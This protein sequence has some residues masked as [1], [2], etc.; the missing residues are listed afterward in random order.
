MKNRNASRIF[1]ML[2]AMLFFMTSTASASVLGTQNGGW[3]SDMGGGAVY[4]NSSYASESGNQTENYVEYTPNSEA[5]PV[6]V[7]G[8]SVYGSRTISS[9]AEYMQKNSLRPLIG[10][11]G[12]YFSPKTGIPMGYTV[13]DGQ[14]FSKESGIQDAVGFRADGTGFI[15]KIGIDASLSHNDTK[16]NIQYINK[17]PQKGF[18]WVYM[19]DSNFSDT[20][21]TDFK[22]IYVTCSRELGDMSLNS[23]MVLRVDD[24]KISDSAIKI[25]DG[26]YVFVMDVDGQ[27]EY[28]D[29]LSHLAVG[30]TV[31][32]RNSVYGAERND[33]TSASHIMSSIGGRLLNNGVVGSGFSAGTAPRT[34]V[35]VK[36]N[37]NII[38][39]TI[40]GRQSGYSKG[41]TIAS[42]AKRMQELGC[43]DAINLDGGG[44]T[45]I[46]GIFPGSES[47]LVTNRPSDGAQ[48]R[49]ANYI[50]LQD[51]REKTDIVWYVDWREIDNNKFLAGT[52]HQLEAL[53]VYD[54]GNYKMNG[55][56]GVTY[57]IQN[58]ETAQSEVS[59]TGLVT[60]RGTGAVKVS[61]TGERYNKD[62]S[63]E[64]YESPDEICVT[65]ETTGEEV[66]E[67]TVYEGTMTNFS[68]EAGAYVG[69][70]RLLSYPS[71]FKWEIIGTLAE[72]DEDGT[73]SVKDDGTET[74]LLRVSAGG[75]VKEIP[76]NTVKKSAF[77]DVRSH[78][79]KD[80]IEKMAQSGII[81]GFNENGVS[82]F[83]PDEKITRVQFAA[84]T[85]K[86]LGI[87]IEDYSNTKLE[88]SDADSIQPWALDYVKAVTALGYIKGRSDDGGKTVY[89]DPENKI[90][91]AEAFTIVS[92]IIDVQSQRALAFS[93]AD[94]IPQWAV[95]A[96]SG[97][98]ERGIVKGFEDNTIRPNNHITRAE[99]AVLIDNSGI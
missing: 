19:L 67:L 13:I 10:I 18:S 4:I 87:S 58:S 46:G 98:E 80:T 35:G 29:M 12:D 70:A 75:T 20:T 11:N 76:I 39:Y 63:F 90:T 65:D 2:T 72:V 92:R 86:A 37:G 26:K 79:A 74:A 68:L 59:D 43:V 23:E 21:K 1:A 94:D 22:A 69:G 32:F 6:V 83:K 8:A 53:K 48:R 9:A 73:V 95:G 82:L 41:V 49:C 77:E 42:L 81:D 62:F 84:M 31:V 15:D 91:R 5:V 27:A 36:D 30:D 93:D 17:W 3:Q 89:F 64:V 25:P 66:T 16:I 56:S 71:L 44:S 88:F 14:I 28:F 54:T 34:A 38:F 85:V 96:V 57:S 24:I 33:W 55:L 60:F 50:F 7:N 45:A 61:V 40:D 52:S 51:L 99:S 47:F 97:L 78:W